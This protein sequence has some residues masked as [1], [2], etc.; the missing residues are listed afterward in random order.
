MARAED[1]DG[2]V[3]SDGVRCANRARGPPRT[4]VGWA[5]RQRAPRRADE[6]GRTG[7]KAEPISRTSSAASVHHPRG[8]GGIPRISPPQGSRPPLAGRQD[9][10]A[11][12]DRAHLVVLA[13]RRNADADHKR[14]QP[15]LPEYPPAGRPRPIG[16]HGDRPAST[17]EQPYVG[18]CPGRTES[19]I[20]GAPGRRV[21]ELVWLPAA[22]QGGVRIAGRRYALQVSGSL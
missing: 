14:H 2:N 4:R 21:R 5:E 10:R 1:S 13:R 12:P 19:P 7:G 6:T 20:R 8:G 17:A 18:V 11:L 22:W 3:S 9:Q 16:E 15:A